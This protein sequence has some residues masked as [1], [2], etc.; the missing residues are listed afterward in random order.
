MIGT[1]SL[2]KVSEGLNAFRSDIENA[3]RQVE[4]LE[5]TSYNS[6]L[7]VVKRILESAKDGPGAPEPRL[8]YSSYLSYLQIDQYLHL[9]VENGLLK[10]DSAART[11]RITRKG[12][13]FLSAI[14]LMDRFL[15]AVED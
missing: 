13:E 6:N 9:L 12:T 4:S 2:I 14:R 8:M 11:Y 5:P 1:Y 15:K 3:G 7:D 10:Y